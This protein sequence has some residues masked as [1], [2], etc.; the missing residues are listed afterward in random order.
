M[1]DW[2]ALIAVVI[3]CEVG[4][5][6]FRQLVSARRLPGEVVWEFNS[7]SKPRGWSKASQ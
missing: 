1:D 6:G 7:T 4:L 2:G 5:L 3:D